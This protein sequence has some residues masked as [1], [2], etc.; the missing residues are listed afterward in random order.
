MAVYVAGWSS[1]VARRAHN[2]KVAGSNPAPAMQDPPLA[3]RVLLF[4]GV[5]VD[6]AGPAVNLP[7][8][9]SF[10]TAL[11]WQ[12]ATAQSDGRKNTGRRPTRHM[13]LTYISM[14]GTPGCRAGGGQSLPVTQ[15]LQTWLAFASQERFLCWPLLC[16]ACNGTV[17]WISIAEPSGSISCSWR[18][19]TRRHTVVPPATKSARGVGAL[20]L[21][22]LGDAELSSA[23]VE[24]TRHRHALNHAGSEHVP[25][26]HPS[27]GAS[28]PSVRSA[29]P[30]PSSTKGVLVQMAER[31]ELLARRTPALGAAMYLP[32]TP[33]AFSMGADRELIAKD[34]AGLH[35]ATSA[36]RRAGRDEPEP[37]RLGVAG[38]RTDAT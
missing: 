12:E 31:G 29:C 27:L 4:L 15:R 10:S 36:F 3:R 8:F 14:D 16:P 34:G 5:L 11:E 6:N 2:P 9:M 26:R 17:G 7:S 38:E 37:D 22:L 21:W 1:L 33:A 23:A 32:K 28:Y 19:E 24:R 20:C 25:T 18:S 30:M 35:D 13:S